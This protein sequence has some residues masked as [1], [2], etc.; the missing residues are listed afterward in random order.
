MPPETIRII[1]LDPFKPCRFP[2][3][4]QFPQSRWNLRAEKCT[5]YRSV[6]HQSGRVFARDL[7]LLPSGESL[8]QLSPCQREFLPGLPSTSVD[9]CGTAS[10]D[11]RFINSLFK[12]HNA[13]RTR[14][15]RK[16]GSA[17]SDP[18]CCSTNHFRKSTMSFTV[19]VLVP[20]NCKITFAGCLEG[21]LLL[22]QTLIVWKADKK[23]Q[24][25]IDT[26][27]LSRDFEHSLS[28]YR[29]ISFTILNVI[30]ALAAF[31]SALNWWI[32]C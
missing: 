23:H 13:G 20:R 22:K 17:N 19:A 28:S 7:V 18:S 15:Q 31:S 2:A 4:V 3:I 11:R 26:D 27:V 30:A 21:K 25:L 16:R 29:H 32:D 12:T 8:L 14:F 24:S 5:D 1:G 10:V 9:T 6:T